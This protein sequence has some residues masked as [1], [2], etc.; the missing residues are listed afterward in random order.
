MAHTHNESIILNTYKALYM[1]IGKTMG[2]GVD[3][4]SVSIISILGLYQG[5]CFHFT[6]LTVLKKPLESRLV[7]AYHFAAGGGHG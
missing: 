1:I 2:W 7:G 4:L 6:N 5:R 3:V